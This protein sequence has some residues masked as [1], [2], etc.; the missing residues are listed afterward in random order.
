M[1]VSGGEGVGGDARAEEDHLEEDAAPEFCE[2]RGAEVGIVNFDGL[3]PLHLYRGLAGAVDFGGGG[4]D[5]RDSGVVEVIFNSSTSNVNIPSAGR[6]FVRRSSH[7]DEY[8]LS[9]RI[10]GEGWTAE[11]AFHVA[12]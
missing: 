5:V 11:S 7:G 1:G 9:K 4:F 12:I 2:C 10:R 3:A 8:E 6:L